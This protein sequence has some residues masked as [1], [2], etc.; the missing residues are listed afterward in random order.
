MTY[1][2]PL[3]SFHTHKLRLRL[4]CHE[5]AF[6]ATSCVCWKTA[7]AYYWILRASNSPI[8]Y[9]LHQSRDWR[10]YRLLATRKADLHRQGF[11]CSYERDNTWMIGRAALTMLSRPLFS[12]RQRKIKISRITCCTRG[13]CWCQAVYIVTERPRVSSWD[14]FSTAEIESK[15]Y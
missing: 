6:K 5:D 2:S 8:I 13:S 15:P 1:V 4:P 3:G 7:V 12:S 10:L 11:F 14:G 9:A